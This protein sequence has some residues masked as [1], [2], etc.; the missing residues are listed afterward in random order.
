MADLIAFMKAE[1]PGFENAFLVDSSDMLGVRETRHVIGEYILTNDDVLQQRRFDD[2]IG[3]NCGHM[4]PGKE[5]HSPDGAEG[6]ESDQANR[7]D[8]WSRVS[9]EIPYRAIVARDVDNLFLAGRHMSATH[10][11]D[12]ITRHIPPCI[13]VGQA[14]GTAAALCSK[15]DVAPKHLD[16][17]LLQAELRKAGVNFGRE[18]PREGVPAT[19]GEA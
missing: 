18:I 6:A 7:G 14:A 9:H 3:L 19:A 2:V 4:P 11:A 5:V 12:R 16:V 8:A 10:E 13:L 17:R 1:V 15:L